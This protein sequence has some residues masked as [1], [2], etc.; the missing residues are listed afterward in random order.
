MKLITWI[1]LQWKVRA[2]AKFYPEPA[3]FPRARL[4]DCCCE[5]ST[6]Q[7]CFIWPL[8]R[9]A[10]LFWPIRA[11][12]GRRTASLLSWSTAYLPTASPTSTQT[13]IAAEGQIPRPL[14]SRLIPRH[15]TRTPFT[16]ALPNSFPRNLKFCQLSNWVK[17]RLV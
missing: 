16:Q 14:N 2:A 1:S 4:L 5:P 11:S 10:L 12:A 15:I 13:T 7:M 6:S 17:L 9:S 8:L 3:N